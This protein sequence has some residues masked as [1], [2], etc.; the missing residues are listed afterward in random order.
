[1]SYRLLLW[2]S[3]SHEES[4]SG[5]SSHHDGLR[6]LKPQAKICLPPSSCFRQLSPI[7]IRRATNREGCNSLK[8]CCGYPWQPNSAL[9]VIAG[10]LISPSTLCLFNLDDLHLYISVFVLFIPS[11][12]AWKSLPVSLKLLFKPFPEKW[13]SS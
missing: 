4:R 5:I 13:F 3:H 1:M 9:W 12:C 6:S 7:V 11:I 10:L 2:I 8:G